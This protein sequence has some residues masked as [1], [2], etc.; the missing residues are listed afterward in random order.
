MIVIENMQE[1]LQ[2]VQKWH[3]DNL[4]VIEQLKEQTHDGASI[5]A[6]EN[7]L[8]IF[9]ELPLDTLVIVKEEFEESLFEDE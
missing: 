8:N 1:L 3:K 7:C 6:Y 4:W 9:S 2:V 5:A